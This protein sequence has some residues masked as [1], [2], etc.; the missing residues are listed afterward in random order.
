MFQQTS[1]PSDASVLPLR[2]PAPQTQ[3]GYSRVH[4]TNVLQPV[5]VVYQPMRD[6]PRGLP[7]RARSESDVGLGRPAWRKLRRTSPLPPARVGLTKGGE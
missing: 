1:L 7:V 3:A 4:P 2:P 6:R 5:T